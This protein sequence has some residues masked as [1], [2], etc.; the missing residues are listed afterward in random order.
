MARRGGTHE[1]E[2]LDEE[3]LFHLTRGTELI[4]A[5]DADGARAALERART[6]RPKDVKV[7]GLLGQAYYRLARFEDAGDVWQR[8][9]DESPVEPIARVNLGLAWLKAKRYP[10]A[11]RQ[12]EIALDLNPDHR[13][14]MGYL[15]L[16][17]LEGGD[18]AAARGW[19]AKAGSEQ[20][21][22]RCDAL[23]AG[24]TASEPLEAGGEAAAGEAPADEARIDGA[25]AD[26]PPIDEAPIDEA[27]ID[28]APID[29]AP[30]DEAPIDEAP[31]Y[32]AAVEEAEIAARVHSL[33]P[34][35][36][37][38]PAPLTA[39]ERA[40]PVAEP[41]PP[42]P[43][44][45]AP[46]P[47]DA[48][49]TLSAWAAARVVAADG[50]GAF[51]VRDGV[52]SVSVRGEVRV[53]LAG[54]FA[55]RG[56]VALAGDVKRFRGRTT[57]TPFGEGAERMHRASGEGVLL[58]RAGD[59]RLTA[60]ELGG[61]AAYFREDAVCG[62]DGT[63]AFENGRV[64]SSAGELNLVHIRGEGALLLATRGAPVA[65]DVLPGAPLRLP[66]A[67]LVGWTGALTPRL[68]PLAEDAEWTPLAVEL[69]GEGRAIADP[70]AVAEAGS[71]P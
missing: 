7:L 59:R 33:E 34:L 60:I 41:E 46:A 22:A 20:M 42:A 57:D 23:L 48:P 26:E 45:A 10:E 29:E 27:P 65:V 37:P 36:R 11:A 35:P 14:A 66:V 62:L 18:P 49:A 31:A 2:G 25:A 24:A 5:G 28:E 15:G 61:E 13:K 30:I 58:L 51:D 32:E 38:V 44:A 21:V 64:P 67:A 52:L 9:V 43:P 1:V 17:L 55:L 12:L 8:L 68:G 63:I 69:T 40:A 70:D 16:A 50:R 56:D 3:F 39:E 47:A 53:R 19:F 6:L 54:L 4:G 71:A